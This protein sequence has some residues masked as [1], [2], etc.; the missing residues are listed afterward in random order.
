[1]GRLFL[2]A[3][4]P[5]TM[6][7]AATLGLASPASADEPTEGRSTVKITIQLDDETLTATLVD[8]TTTRDFVS[9]LPL[10]LTL[11]D[12]AATEKI[13]DL[14]RRL[15]TAGAPAG[16]DP[17]VGDIA[18]YAP[19]GNLAIF[20]RDFEYSAGLIK[21]GRIDGD[22]AVLRRPGEIKATIEPMRPSEASD[23]D[24]RE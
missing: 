21:L 3:I 12:Y 24:E 1:M 20:H 5:A 8:T 17:D 6:L 4:I 13:S 16:Y 9:L 23:R 15:S 22:V 18:Y 10:V 11:E 14:P 7:G 2:L 19:W